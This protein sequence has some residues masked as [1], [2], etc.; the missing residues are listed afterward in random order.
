MTRT[1]RRN[2]SKPNA[3]LGAGQLVSALWNTA[4]Q[5]GAGSC[6]FNVYRMSPSDGC[7]SQLLRPADVPDLVKLCQVLAVAF[8]EDASISLSERRTLADL[9]IRLDEITRTRD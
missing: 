2:R 5:I 3:I 4:D 9:A 7:V 6:R 8:A 1:K